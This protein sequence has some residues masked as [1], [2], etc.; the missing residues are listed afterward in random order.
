MKIVKDTLSLLVETWDDP[1]DY[2]NAVASGPLPSYDYIE[3][4]E[5]EVV[6]E[7]DDDELAAYHE[8][9]EDFLNDLDIERPGGVLSW[10]LVVDKLEG[11]TM[12]LHAEDVEGD[13]DWGPDEPDYD[14]ED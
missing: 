11:H 7:L 14:P 5:G 9:P 8:C 2:P 12:T 1:G 10:K 4:V 3:G 6:V 13:P